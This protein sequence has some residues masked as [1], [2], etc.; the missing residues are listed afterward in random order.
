MDLNTINMDRNE[1]RRQFLASEA[2]DAEEGT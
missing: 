2:R 1:A